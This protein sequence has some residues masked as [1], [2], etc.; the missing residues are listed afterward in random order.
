MY[1]LEIYAPIDSIKDIRLLDSWLTSSIEIGQK[2]ELL[3]LHGYGKL[4]RDISTVMTSCSYELSDAFDYINSGKEWIPIV[5]PLSFTLIES[6]TDVNAVAYNL[7]SFREGT[8][9]GY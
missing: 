8:L 1:K 5:V 6:H 4:F 3:T 2:P 7:T 9:Q